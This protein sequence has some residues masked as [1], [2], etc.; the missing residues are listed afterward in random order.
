MVSRR[1]HLNSLVIEVKDGNSNVIEA[2]AK[3][4]GFRT[5]EIRDKQFLTTENPSWSKV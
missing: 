1:T 4:V 5:A 2:T 3:K